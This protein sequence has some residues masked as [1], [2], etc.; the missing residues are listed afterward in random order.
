MAG[1]NGEVVVVLVVMMG[2]SCPSV[3]QVIDYDTL[4]HSFV[5]LRFVRRVLLIHPS[6][7]ETYF[8]RQSPLPTEPTPPRNGRQ[9]QRRGAKNL[10]ATVG[11]RRND[12]DYPRADANRASPLLLLGSPRS[13]LSSSCNSVCSWKLWRFVDA[14]IIFEGSRTASGGLLIIGCCC[15]LFE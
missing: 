7:E 13:A 12:Q 1:N 2:S 6:N 15:E 9:R 5:T 4:T 8:G 11:E 3:R 14:F 10:D